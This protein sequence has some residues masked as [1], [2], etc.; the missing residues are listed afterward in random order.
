MDILQIKSSPWSAGGELTRDV[1][2]KAYRKMSL[3]YHPDKHAGDSAMLEEARR[4]QP[5][6]NEAREV[7]LKPFGKKER[8]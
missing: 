6:I 2:Q 5:K 3:R 7:L 1:V 8:T 4:M